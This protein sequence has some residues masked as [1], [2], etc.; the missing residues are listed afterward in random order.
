[1]QEEGKEIEL[2]FLV[3]WFLT[4]WHSDKQ[5]ERERESDS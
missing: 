5:R 2:V 3:L 4:C 1:M